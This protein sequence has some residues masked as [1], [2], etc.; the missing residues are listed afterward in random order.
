MWYTQRFS[1]SWSGTYKPGLLKIETSYLFWFSSNENGHRSPINK[2][3]TE[4]EDIC[5]PDNLRE[6][7]AKCE[8]MVKNAQKHLE[9]MKAFANAYL[10]MASKMFSFASQSV[11]IMQASS[12]CDPAKFNLS[13]IIANCNWNPAI[14]DL[15]SQVYFTQS[16]A[17][18]LSRV[19]K[20][21]AIECN[22]DAKGW[23]L[24]HK[25]S[26]DSCSHN[27]DEHGFTL[28]GP[29]PRCAALLR[30]DNLWAPSFG[31]DGPVYNYPPGLG[32]N[33]GEIPI[34]DGSLYEMDSEATEND[35]AR[36]C[37]DSSGFDPP[38]FFTLFYRMVETG[39]SLEKGCFCFPRW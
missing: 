15:L 2:Y 5:S 26:Q 33:L 13:E 19:M 17:L 36:K 28:Q 30:D 38:F 1:A 27:D 10:Q 23:P 31:S 8:D 11:A 6:N 39:N 20:Q 37:Y 34:S 16:R 18:F 24:P 9:S 35:C 22:P 7:L 14:Q 12:F 29:F 4:A 32:C 3:I 21:I 25:C